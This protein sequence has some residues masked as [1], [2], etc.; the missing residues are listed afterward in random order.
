MIPVWK[1]STWCELTANY[2][3]KAARYSVDN[4]GYKYLT[5]AVT[6]VCLLKCVALNRFI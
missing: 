1:R 3:M 2:R 4:V 6:F 5:S